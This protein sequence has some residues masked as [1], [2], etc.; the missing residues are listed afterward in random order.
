MRLS[1]AQELRLLVKSDVQYCHYFIKGD[2]ITSF[3]MV[4]LGIPIDNLTGM[5][6][7]RTRCEKFKSYVSSRCRS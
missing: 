6:V 5:S 4:D 7:G 2:L 3:F 1:R